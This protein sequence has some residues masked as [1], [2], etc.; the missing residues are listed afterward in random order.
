MHTHNEK[1]GSVCTTFPANI[2]VLLITID[3]SNFK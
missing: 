3:Y 2:G 1:P